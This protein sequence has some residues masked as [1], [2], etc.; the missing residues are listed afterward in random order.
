MKLLPLTEAGESSINGNKA[1]PSLF[2]SAKQPR[3]PL[4]QQAALPRFH[5]NNAAIL[6]GHFNVPG[7]DSKHFIN[8]IASDLKRAWLSGP[9]PGG[10]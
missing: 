10:Y 2:D 9:N 4:T 6:V 3:P 7:N 1:L 5:M 8:W